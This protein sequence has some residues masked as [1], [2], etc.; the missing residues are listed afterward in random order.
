MK[1]G[2]P[3]LRRTDSIQLRT[4]SRLF[5]YPIFKP[6]IHWKVSFMRKICTFEKSPDDILFQRVWI[7]IQKEKK[8]HD[9]VP[10]ESFVSFEKFAQIRLF[11]E[12]VI[13]I[14]EIEV[15]CLTVSWW[16][17]IIRNIWIHFARISGEFA[18]SLIVSRTFVGRP[19]RSV[20]WRAS[21]IEP[22]KIAKA[23]FLQTTTIE[24]DDDRRIRSR[25]AGRN[26]ISPRLT[27]II[28]NLLPSIPTFPLSQRISIECFDKSYPRVSHVTFVFILFE[29]KNRNFLLSLGNLFNRRNRRPISPI[30][31]HFLPCFSTYRAISETFCPDYSSGMVSVT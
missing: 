18:T 2:A 28:P 20:D 10:S 9:N 12:T 22:G 1:I 8:E 27:A 23:E 5:T 14:V 19:F 13:K 17:T 30:F 15:A 26:R 7:D 21:R 31:Q 6:M 24:T 4:D 11:I 29:R 25:F 16:N 3:T